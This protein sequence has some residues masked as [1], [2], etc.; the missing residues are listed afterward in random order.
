MNRR[1]VFTA[2]TGA[3]IACAMPG[4]N[5]AEI[6][7][8]FKKTAQ[9]WVRCRMYELQLGDVFKLGNGPVAELE[10][11]V[12]GLPNKNEDGGWQVM[13]ISQPPIT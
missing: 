7:P 1:Q 2:A 3:I 6:Y 13:A 8:L 11:T 4:D 10:L 12:K 9:G 5:G